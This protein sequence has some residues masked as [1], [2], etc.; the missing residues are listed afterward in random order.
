MSATSETILG[1]IDEVIK[2]GP[3][4]LIVHTAINDLTNGT[5]LLNQPKEILKQV[6]KVF[7]NA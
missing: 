4:C 2:N 3:G 7:Q 5:K 1:I 6:K